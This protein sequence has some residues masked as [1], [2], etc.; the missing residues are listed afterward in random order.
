MSTLLGLQPADKQAPV[1]A[2]AMLELK[3]VRVGGEASRKKGGGKKA[4]RGWLNKSGEE[5]G[6]LGL[7]DDMSGLSGFHWL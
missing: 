2:R 4:A 6:Y 3:W 5:D 7:R 1:R